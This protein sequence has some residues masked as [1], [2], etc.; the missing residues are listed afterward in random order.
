MRSLESFSVADEAAGKEKAKKKKKKGS[1]K[2]Q[3]VA[4]KSVKFFGKGKN[5]LWAFNDTTDLL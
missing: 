3:R 2:A 1:K 4:G 5:L